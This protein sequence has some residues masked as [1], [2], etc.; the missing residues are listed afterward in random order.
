MIQLQHPTPSTSLEWFA[1]EAYVRQ[2]VTIATG[3]D[4]AKADLSQV[5][6][7]FLYHI[8]DKIGDLYLDYPK[9]YEP[10]GIEQFTHKGKTYYLPNSV[11]IAGQT[12]LQHNGRAKRFV[13]ASNL[14]KEWATAKKETMLNVP[15]IVSAYVTESPTEK[16]NEYDV[17]KRAELFADLPMSTVWEVFFC[18]SQ[19]TARLESVILKSTEKEAAAKLKRAILVLKAGSTLL[20]ARGIIWG[21][22][23]RVKRLFGKLLRQ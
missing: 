3:K 21:W 13:E 23:Q 16:W 18:I 22:R 14:L 10:K 7:Y 6:V 20:R 11:R 15:L 9:T 12:I 2:A 8:A 1:H 17:I 4:C 5:I 19:L